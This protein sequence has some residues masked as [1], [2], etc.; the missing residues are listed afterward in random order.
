[1][2]DVSLLAVAV[3][4]VA[5]FVIGFVYYGAVGVP[6]AAGDGAGAVAVRR[7]AWQLP[8]VELARNLVLAAVVVGVAAAADVSSAGGGLLLGLVLW[9]GFPLV[10]WTGALFHE[11]VPPRTAL[12][13]GGDWLLKLLAIGLIAGLLG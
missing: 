7:P 2:P 11:G 9:I 10:L 13:H 3:G 12:V 8:V 5:A 1:M 4:T 6:A